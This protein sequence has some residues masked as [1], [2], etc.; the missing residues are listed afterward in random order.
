MVG[1][2]V[3]LSRGRPLR[4]LRE[5]PWRCLP[6]Y[7]RRDLPPC[8]KTTGSVAGKHVADFPT[9]VDQCHP[10]RN[11]ILTPDDVTAGMG[12]P[13]WWKCSRGP[14][15]ECRQ[16][17]RCVGPSQALNVSHPLVAAQWHPTKRASTPRPSSPAA[18]SN[19]RGGNA[20]A[21]TATSG[22]RG[23]THERASS[24]RARPRCAVMTG[25]G[26]PKT[27][28]DCA[29]I[30]ER[31]AAIAQ[32]SSG[33]NLVGRSGLLPVA[34]QLPSRPRSVPPRCQAPIRRQCAAREGQSSIVPSA[35]GPEGRTCP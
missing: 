26:V 33:V 18:P 2:E 12:L 11:G 32:I 30:R 1:F 3:W 9:L 7:H 19:T 31:E 15:H 10:T 25:K 28:E 35:K 34:S 17:S 20:T 4:D 14:D 5:S 24:P 13:V 6:T 21:T 16:Q 8:E 22:G 27:P 29:Q 23:S